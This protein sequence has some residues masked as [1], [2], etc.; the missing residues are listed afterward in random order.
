MINDE[1]E[2]IGPSKNQE[3]PNQQLFTCFSSPLWGYSIWFGGGAIQIN[4]DSHH[5]LVNGEEAHL[6]Y[7]GIAEVVRVYNA[8]EE[9][10]TKARMLNMIKRAQTLINPVRNYSRSR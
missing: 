2:P 5:R 3:S 4:M 6:S 7:Q 1:L 10:E 9:S 8:E